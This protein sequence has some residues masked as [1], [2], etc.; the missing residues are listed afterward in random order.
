MWTLTHLLP[1][2]NL[3]RREAE[4][5]DR[6]ARAESGLELIRCRLT[7]PWWYTP[8]SCGRKVGQQLWPTDWLSDFNNRQQTSRQTSNTTQSGL[9]LW[10][11]QNRR[12]NASQSVCIFVAR[13]N[14]H[15]PQPSLLLGCSF[16][17]SISIRE[18]FCARFSD[19][20][21]KFLRKDFKLEVYS[22]YSWLHFSRISLQLMINKESFLQ[23]T[24]SG[25]V[26]HK[27]VLDPK[28]K[29]CSHSFTVMWFTELSGTR[30]KRWIKYSINSFIN[31]S[32]TDVFLICMC[33][34]LEASTSSL[35]SLLCQAKFDK[36]TDSLSHIFD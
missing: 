23:C 8:C 24:L 11:S 36:Q 26:C 14:S 1:H 32:K 30:D 34:K 27:F 13:L 35:E 9:L 2:L 4:E 21:A 25:T 28:K 7:V 22:K 12:E 5:G 6:R 18:Y 10:E 17:G 20:C 15:L 19:L 3:G 33:Y 29:N 31:E 16:F